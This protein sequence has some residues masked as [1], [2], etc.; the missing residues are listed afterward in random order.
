MDPRTAA[1]RWEDKTVGE[2]P[3]YVTT[4]ALTRELRGLHREVR[5]QGE[6]LDRLA[7]A[8]TQ[9]TAA[10]AAL[11]AALERKRNSR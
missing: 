2:E 3:D 5:R 10:L 9:Q 11:T 8:M 1:Q 7:V 4:A 6:A